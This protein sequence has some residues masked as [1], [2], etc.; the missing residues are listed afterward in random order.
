[1]LEQTKTSVL[2]RTQHGGATRDQPPT[3]AVQGEGVCILPRFSPICQTGNANERKDAHT[4]KYEQAVE[5]YLRN[6]GNSGKSPNTINSYKS[7][8]R[9][10]GGYL[11]SIGIGNVEE[12]TNNHLVDWKAE[13][14]ESLS[15]SSLRLYCTIANGFFDF[16][17]E[18]SIIVSSPYKPKLMQVAVKDTDRKDTLSHVL[19]EADFR[20]I[21]LADNPPNMHRKAIA[22]NKAILALLITSGIRCE[23]LCR[24]THA[25]LDY[26]NRTIRIVNAKGGKNA[27]VPYTS[28][29]FAAV[30]EYLASAAHPDTWSQDDPLFGFVDGDGI[31][32]PYGRTQLSNIVEASV[33][34]FV[35]KSGFRSHAMRHTFASIL[36]NRG[37][38]DG[39]VSILLMHSDGSGAPVTARYIKRNNTDLFFAVDN[40][41]NSILVNEV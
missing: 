17:V 32:T 9:L 22:R 18:M 2:P 3:K 16:C 27:D 14:A 21:V 6:C 8:L 31:W 24:L 10:L 40:I 28:V 33:R 13:F 34:A 39:E 41:F 35:G 5:Q 7:A 23:S 38:T 19:T 29:A 36:S 11:R 20:A 15:P 4:M 1:M 26:T 25:D 12:V 30:Q 37:L